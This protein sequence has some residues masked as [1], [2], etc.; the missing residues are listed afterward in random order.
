MKIC[1]IADTHFGAR[2]DSVYFQLYQNDFFTNTFIPFL[3]RER[4]TEVV[5][6]GDLF[7]KRKYINYTSLDTA[8][9][10]FIDPLVD[11]DIHLHMIVGNHDTY[12]KSDGSVISSKLLFD[13]YEKS[14]FMKIYD[15]PEHINIGS[16]EFLIMPWIF[17]AMH[18]QCMTLIEKSNAD[19]CCGHFEMSGVPYQG[20]VLAKKG[21]SPKIFDKFKYVF[22]GH[23]HKPSYFYVG[24][25]YE[26]KW[27]DYGD[28]KRVILFDTETGLTQSHLIAKPIHIKVIYDGSDSFDNRNYKNRII[29]L[30]VKKKTDIQHYESFIAKIEAQNPYKLQI[31]DEYLYND[32]IDNSS[33]DCDKDTFN[34]L[35]DYIDELPNF[36]DKEISIM[37]K[38]M[39]KTYDIARGDDD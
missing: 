19:V 24:S 22:S 27:S 31:N 8:K 11:N 10:C 6:L 3:K 21:I 23:Y 33:S 26:I 14:G 16:M 36:D 28:Q 38:I 34:I 39:K 5:H 29:K 9:R 17:P 25:P 13:Q 30:Y 37:K 7:D 18:D 4:I 20:N 32:S 15:K 35:S 12:Y 1:F 2:N